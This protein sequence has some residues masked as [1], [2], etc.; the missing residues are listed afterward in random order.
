MARVRDVLAYLCE[1]YPQKSELSNARLTKMV[2]L[3]DWKSAIERDMQLTDIQWFFNH[4]GPYV[5]DV[6]EVAESDPAFNVRSAYNIYGDPKEIISVRDDV[7]YPSLEEE[8][9]DILDFVINSSASKNWDQFIRLV[10]STYPMVT[11][12]KYAKLDLVELA[13][14]YAAN[15]ALLD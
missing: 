8:D 2:Y 9:K 5:D 12:D 7:D 15:Q 1:K 4:Y 10:Y 3:A 11:L 14:E 13:H 6:I